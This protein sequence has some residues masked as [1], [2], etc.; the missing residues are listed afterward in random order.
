MNTTMNKPQF[1]TAS[2]SFSNVSP[3]H[4][5][6]S[7][8]S[9][10]R[11]SLFMPSPPPPVG[12]PSPPAPPANAYASPICSR[13]PVWSTNAFRLALP[14]DAA[15]FFASFFAS[16]RASR[17]LR[18]HAASLASRPP[19]AMR[20]RTPGFPSLQPPTH[21]PAIH[22]DGMLLRPVSAASAGA[23]PAP[24]SVRS[25]STAVKGTPASASA[26]LAAA[27]KGQYVALKTTTSSEAMSAFTLAREASGS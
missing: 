23:N 16:A 8:I 11:L 21:S 9:G 14:R 3:S 25:H 2:P 4:G 1:F 10:G 5:S 22:T 12:G 26:A 24:P 27:L 13:S 6:F 7:S 19:D 18:E 15:S 20:G 17:T